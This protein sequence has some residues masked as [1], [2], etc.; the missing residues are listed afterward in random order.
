MDAQTIQT[1]GLP[2]TVPSTPRL[3]IRVVDGQPFEHPTTEE[4][5][6]EA[7]PEVDLD[8]L[9][10]TFAVFERVRMP[11]ANE[12]DVFEVPEVSY[13]W[14][15]GVVKDVWV[16]R[17]MTDAERATRVAAEMKS[18]TE[19][20]AGRKRIWTEY[21][22]KQTD[23]TLVAQAQIHIDKLDQIVIVD[24]FNVAWPEIPFDPRDFLTP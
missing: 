2:E 6:R 21:V 20:L 4:N 3:F 22:L 24:P 5:M 19:Q 17:P 9:P 7:F 12:Y 10:P 23:T 16:C 1:L 13:Q 15:D 18:V 8:N 14:V 11:W